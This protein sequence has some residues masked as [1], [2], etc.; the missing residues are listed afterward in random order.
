MSGRK[1]RVEYKLPPWCSGSENCM[2]PIFIQLGARL[3]QHPA[4][5]ALTP[6]DR[7]C[8]QCM[9]L[10]AKGK[11]DFQFS[12]ATA[13]KYGIAARTLIDNVCRLRKAGFIE[14]IASGRNNQTSS[15]YSFSIR[16]KT[17]P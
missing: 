12:R 14:L 4:F 2:E 6:S 9:L 17:P 13:K 16:W 3:M 1:A 15:D 7:W 10:E 11:P 8:Y 5:L